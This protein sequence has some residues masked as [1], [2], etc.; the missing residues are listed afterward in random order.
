MPGEEALGAVPDASGTSFRVWAPN[1]D[2]V[3]V[4]GSFNDWSKEATPLLAEGN[5][6]WALR[7]EN[8]RPGD[9]YKYVVVSRGQPT[10]KNDPYARNVTGS[11]G[12]S[13]IVDSTFDWPGGDYRTPTWDELVLYELHVGTYWDEPGGP[14]G[15]FDSAIRHLDHLTELGVTAIELMPPMEFA[16]GFSWG[17]NPAH[18]FALE[19]DYGGPDALKRFV[20]EAHARGMA[21]ILDVV[22]NHFGPSD[23]DLWCFDGW[24]QNDKGGIYFYNDW[25]SN[26]PWGDTRP[27]YGRPEVRRYIHDNAMM[28]LEEA[29]VDGL[30]WDATAYIRNVYGRNGDPGSDIPDGWQLMQWINHEIH[31]RQPWKISIAE[32]LRDNPWVTKPT[33]VGGAGFDAQW[34]AA[35]VH[36]VRRT[37]IA[38]EDRDRDLWALKRAI[39]HNYDGRALAR[40]IYTESHDEV[41]NGHARVPEEIW[42]GN[43]S[44]W[45]SKK[46]STLGAA[47]VMTSPGIPMLFQGQELLEDR[48]FSDHDPLDWSRLERFAGIARLYR[49]LIRLRRNW[50]DTTRGLRGAGLNVHHVNDTDKLIG[51]YRY[52]HGGPRDGVLVVLNLSY[53]AY[54]YYLLGFPEAGR[55]RVR[56]NSDWD[57]Y[58]SEFG[59]HASFDVE[60]FAE[61]RDGM[62]FSAGVSIGP[63]SA[64]IL[65]RD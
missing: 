6:Y 45:Y 34:D 54:D 35:F 57:G 11:I 37:I 20:A 14:P 3:N 59:N 41:A 52:H 1:A 31:L 18:P 19:T 30:R 27:D 2:R 62:P 51:F 43:A 7:V 56:F 10:L 38:E 28:W 8:A 9:E 58:S 49:D 29:R 4:A 22:Y 60:T 15:N 16:G 39:E 24:S 42:P 44:S 47:L 63:Y 23:L 17:Y 53:R 50:Y 12:N 13:V 61:P 48:W 46:R 26:T 65:S 5:G 32:D 64:L 21:V 25:R 40:V 36:P 33:W 55:W